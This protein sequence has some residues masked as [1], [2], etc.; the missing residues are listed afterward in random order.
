MLD[1]KQQQNTISATGKQ[2]FIREKCVSVNDLVNKAL[3]KLKTN[4]TCQL[5]LF[6]FN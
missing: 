5:Q 3:T 1:Y 4:M 6:Y 2:I